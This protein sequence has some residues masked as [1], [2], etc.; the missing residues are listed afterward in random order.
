M[1]GLAHQDPSYIAS[2]LQFLNT[3]AVGPHATLSAVG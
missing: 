2:A 1:G 3:F